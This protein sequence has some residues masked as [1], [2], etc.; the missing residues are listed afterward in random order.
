MVKEY[1]EGQLND[2]SEK[3][4]SSQLQYKE[5][6]RRLKELKKNIR[7]IQADTDIDMEIFSPRTQT[8]SL[9]GRLNNCYEE[10]N[11]LAGINDRLRK[12]IEELKEIKTNFEIMWKE[13]EHSN[14]K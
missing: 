8:T 3:L 11:R 10:L 2:A 12:E 13:I 6:E 5:N 1:I 14:I 7:L 9:K 4:F